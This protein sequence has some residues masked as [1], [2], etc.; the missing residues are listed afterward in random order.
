MYSLILTSFTKVEATGARR[1]NCVMRDVEH[2]EWLEDEKARKA[3]AKTNNKTPPVPP[4]KVDEKKRAEPDDD[5]DGRV[6]WRGE[7]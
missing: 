6:W 2:A 7:T 5:Q 3:A 4:K 1:Y